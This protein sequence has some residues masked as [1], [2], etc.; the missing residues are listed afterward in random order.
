ME[1]S[2][3]LLE[4]YNN[5]ISKADALKLENKLEEAKI[6]Y[7]KAKILNPSNSY[8]DE[9]IML[10]NESLKKNNNDKLKIE[11]EKILKKADDYYTAKNYKLARDFYKQA[12]SFEISNGADF[13]NGYA[14]QKNHFN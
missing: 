12:N 9:K 7:E 6:L 8:S 13:S 3:I 2:E 10:I 11:Y 4:Q 5:L 1:A 14:S